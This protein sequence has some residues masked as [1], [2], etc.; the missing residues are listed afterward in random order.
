MRTKKD[1]SP[2]SSE[3]NKDLPPPAGFLI[4]CDVPMK[5]YIVYLNQLKP[6]D[7]KFIITDLDATH[8]L[9]KAKCKDEVMKKVNEWMDE[10]V[11]SSVEKV[12]EDLDMS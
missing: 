3:K 7:K 1:K 8:L 2:G 12:G 6:V 10:N 11:F 5:Q 4:S 9:V